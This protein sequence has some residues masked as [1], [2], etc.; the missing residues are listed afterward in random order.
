MVA[1]TKRKIPLPFDVDKV[2]PIPEKPSNHGFKHL[3]LQ[4]VYLF[5][6]IVFAKMAENPQNK[7]GAS[8]KTALQ[9]QR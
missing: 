8:S 5:C 9:D 1:A 6:G 4:G 3:G 7:E 2:L